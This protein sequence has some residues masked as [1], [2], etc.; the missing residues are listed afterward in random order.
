MTESDTKPKLKRDI[1]HFNGVKPTAINLEHVTSIAIEECRIAF[2]FYTHTL[3][4]DLQNEDE[5]K[6]IFAQLLKYWAEDVV[7]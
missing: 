3:Y 5:A 1:F 2:S 6:M 7:E 4:I